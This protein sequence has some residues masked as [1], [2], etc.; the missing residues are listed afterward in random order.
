MCATYTVYSSAVFIWNNS[1]DATLGAQTQLPLLL[2]LVLASILRVQ[3]FQMKSKKT[4]HIKPNRSTSV[5]RPPNA[6][7]NTNCNSLLCVVFFFL[8]LWAQF[9][10]LAHKFYRRHITLHSKP[11]MRLAP[12]FVLQLHS[13]NYAC[14]RRNH[15]FIDVQIFWMITI[16]KTKRALSNVI[17]WIWFSD[18]LLANLKSQ[19]AALSR[20]IFS[21]LSLLNLRTKRA[22]TTNL[23]PRIR[24]FISFAVTFTCYSIVLYCLG[25]L[26][27][28]GWGKLHHSDP[29]MDL[30][31]LINQIECGW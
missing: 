23:L 3:S 7:N 13:S 9:R 28:A 1:T 29:I 6:I 5:I 22:I 10:A 4:F 11:S 21:H 20:L 17:K 18:T 24:C 30:V 26:G 8:C 14:V 25:W 15:H 16:C 19:I 12:I 2:P 31:N 27:S